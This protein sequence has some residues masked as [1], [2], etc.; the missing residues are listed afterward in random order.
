MVVLC[1]HFPENNG[2]R[3]TFKKG[4]AKPQLSR[5]LVNDAEILL[6]SFSVAR[7]NIPPGATLMTVQIPKLSIPANGKKNFCLGVFK[8]AAA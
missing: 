5:I 6:S 2:T 4:P 7:K 3:K 1:L 8:I